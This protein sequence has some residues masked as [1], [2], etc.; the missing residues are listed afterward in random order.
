MRV[1]YSVCV[2]IMDI[3]CIICRCVY[4]ILTKSPKGPGGTMS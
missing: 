4:A 3:V 1:L 2:L